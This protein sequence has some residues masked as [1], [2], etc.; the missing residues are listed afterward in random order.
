M[1]FSTMSRISG[2][3]WSIRSASESSMMV[4]IRLT[5]WFAKLQMN[6]PPALDVELGFHVEGLFPRPV[7][8]TDH[9]AG[10]RAHL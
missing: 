7:P 2:I 1:A 4:R 6:G 5:A 8:M 9:L 10:V 3:A